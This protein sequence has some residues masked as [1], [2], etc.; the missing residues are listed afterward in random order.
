MSGGTL[1]P[2]VGHTNT[3]RTHNAKGESHGVETKTRHN[4]RGTIIISFGSGRTFSAASFAIS[5]LGGIIDH[6]AESSKSDQCLINEERCDRAQKHRSDRPLNHVANCEKV[7]A[8]ERGGSA[9][10][11]DVL[12]S[13]GHCRPFC[14]LA[15]HL[16]R[17]VPAVLMHTWENSSFNPSIFYYLSGAG[18]RGQLPKR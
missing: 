13:H 3:Q 5:G 12:L 11:V 7:P 16:R 1:T 10:P 14:L 18:S 6:S 17:S 2:P 8:C 15:S 4:A 9:P